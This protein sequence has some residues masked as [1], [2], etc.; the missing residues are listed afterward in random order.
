[1]FGYLDLANRPPL[2]TKCRGFHR[3]SRIRSQAVGL[4]LGTYQ[5]SPGLFSWTHLGLYF[6]HYN[7]VQRHGTLKTTPEVAAG[8][9]SKPMTV[10][11]LIER[12]A[13]YRPPVREGNWK[14]LLDTLPD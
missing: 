8:I 11:E 10:A 7:Y 1:M 9:A 6:A 3:A 4:G 13:D 14:A 5:I 12:T 2:A